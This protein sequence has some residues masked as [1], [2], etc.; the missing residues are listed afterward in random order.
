VGNLRN[1]RIP[2]LP[3]LVVAVIVFVAILWV[4]GVD[5]E[6]RSLATVG[7]GVVVIAI[8]PERFLPT[9]TVSGLILAVVVWGILVV[10]N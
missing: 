1:L 10:F 9:L 7:V 5:W 3:A 6:W 2:V 8:V 4:A